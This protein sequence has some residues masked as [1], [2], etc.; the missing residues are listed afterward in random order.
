MRVSEGLQWR[1]PRDGTGPSAEVVVT[2]NSNRTLG[3]FSEGPKG[4]K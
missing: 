1:R 4:V 3:L 2:G